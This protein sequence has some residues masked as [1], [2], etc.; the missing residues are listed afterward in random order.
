LAAMAGRGL[1]LFE[2]P[3]SIKSFFDAQVAVA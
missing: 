3:H 2:R 1:S